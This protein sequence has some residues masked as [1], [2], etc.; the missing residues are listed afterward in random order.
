[1]LESHMANVEHINRTTGRN[2]AGKLVVAPLINTHLDPSAYPPETLG[3]QHDNDGGGLF[4][5]VNNPHRL[6]F[7]QAVIISL[8]IAETTMAGLSLEAG[9]KILGMILGIWALFYIPLIG[10]LAKI[11]MS[12]IYALIFYR[13]S[14]FAV[15]DL[16]V[17]SDVFNIKYLATDI[18]IVNSPTLYGLCVL[19]ILATLFMQGNLSIKSS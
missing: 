15:P 6:L 2:N 8:Y 13:V 5:I 9:L 17:T 3:A 7:I 14:I 12:F 10:R 18:P 19:V 11:T 16:P 1:M 4:G